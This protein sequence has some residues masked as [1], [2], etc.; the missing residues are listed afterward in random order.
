MYTT[1]ITLGNGA[2]G[3]L[4]LLTSE[5][6]N[7][8]RLKRLKRVNVR[9]GHGVN[10]NGN[11]KGNRKGPTLKSLTR[12]IAALATKFDKF[13]F[14]DDDDESS[15]KEEGTYNRSNAVLTHEIKKK[16]RGGN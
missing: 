14:P 10:D 8:L 15:E 11:G 16:K 4:S 6:N 5:H 12:S 3:Y 7:T 9:H 1:K 2:Y 13:N